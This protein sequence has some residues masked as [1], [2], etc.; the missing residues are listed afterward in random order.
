MRAAFD[1][2]VGQVERAEDDGLA[3][4]GLEYRAIKAGLRGFAGSTG[5]FCLQAFRSYC[6]PLVST[7]ARAN[8]VTVNVTL[9]SL[10]AKPS[11]GLRSRAAAAHG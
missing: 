6:L 9:R 4:Q 11:K 7:L 3:R 5:L 2:H 8:A 10:Q 1:R